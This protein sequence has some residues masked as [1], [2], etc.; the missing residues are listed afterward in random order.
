MKL[1][2]FFYKKERKKEGCA[3]KNCDFPQIIKT[4]LLP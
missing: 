1:F 4:T 2:T 3:I